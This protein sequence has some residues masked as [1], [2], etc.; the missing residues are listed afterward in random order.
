MGNA[1][2]NSRPQNGQTLVWKNNHWTPVALDTLDFKAGKGIVIKDDSISAK[3]SGALWNA[4]KL[5]GHAI[6]DS[7]PHNG[8]TLVWRNNHWTP[9]ALDTVDFK[10][11]AGIVIKDDSIS[12]KVSGALWNANKLMGH[13]IAD[14]MPHN[15]Q[16]LVWRNNHWTPVAL[17]TVDFKAGA[18]IVIK[19][20]SISAKVSDALWNANQLQSQPIDTLSPKKNQI[21]IWDGAKWQAQNNNAGWVVDSVKADTSN[22]YSA[23]KGKVSIGT[24]SPSYLFQVQ[25]GAA[26]ASDSVFYVSNSGRVGIGTINSDTTYKLLVN[27]AIRTKKVVVETGWADYVFDK[28][29]SLMPL[30]QV[31]QFIQANHHLPNIPSAEEISAQGLDVASMQVKTMEKVEEL[32]LYMIQLMKQNKALQKEI[33]E[34][35]SS[36]NQ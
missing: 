9:V 19:D 3:V 24:K 26:Q 31:D 14:S 27:G 1:I 4:N 16:T 2:A 13:A 12:A 23:V 20:D 28:D 36:I 18:G 8:Q 25:G 29:Y 6:A 15:G 33:A 7:M 22:L 30:E 17:D 5:M 21:L 34:L 32:T 11:G 35:K 10:A